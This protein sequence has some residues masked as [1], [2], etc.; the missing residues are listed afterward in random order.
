MKKM[1]LCI[2]CLFSSYAYSS[3]ICQLIVEKKFNEIEEYFQHHV[4]EDDT[5]CL[6]EGYSV[7]PLM[8]A[9][10]L[11]VYSENEKIVRL[12]VNKTPKEQIDYADC[13]GRTA[14]MYALNK[15]DFNLCKLLLEQGATID[16]A[17]SVGLTPLMLATRNGTFDICKLL[18]E[19]AQ[20]SDLGD[21]MV[22]K[23]LSDKDRD[24][25]TPLFFAVDRE[26]GDICR[27]L[28]EKGADINAIDSLGV[29]PLMYASMS[30]E[31]DICRLLLDK[32]AYVNAQDNS[33]QTA[34]MKAIIENNK[35]IVEMLLN[36]P[37]SNLDLTTKEVLEADDED[38]EPGST[39]LMIARKLKREDIIELFLKKESIDEKA[40]R[41]LVNALSTF[42][43]KISLLKQKLN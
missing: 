25:W 4:L 42:T 19:Q 21:R 36:V 28:L 24:G 7:T 8:L 29:T 17:D 12:I 14:L 20:L 35:K 39:A 23:I 43:Q 6:Y 16:I 2:M 11:N 18:L 10:H 37:Q 26:F 5:T 38:I 22:H 40:E 3:S 1:F 30:E 9:I 13:S 27:L 32:G 15:E 34:L 33:G 31:I 41:T